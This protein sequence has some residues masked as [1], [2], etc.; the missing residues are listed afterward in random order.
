MIEV[1][2][3]DGAPVTLY[4]DYAV[5]VLD[6]LD[7]GLST[8]AALRARDDV[9]M[10]TVTGAAP[11]RVVVCAQAFV[12]DAVFAT[13]PAVRRARRF[14]PVPVRSRKRPGGT[15]PACWRDGAARRPGNAQD[16]RTGR[17]NT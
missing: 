14:A 9:D 17:S 16:C 13:L 2:S 4:G 6:V 7:D 3:I 11:V 15:V 12:E 10:V 1:V 5:T 8:A